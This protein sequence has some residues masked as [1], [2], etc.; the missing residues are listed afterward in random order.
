M[1]NLRADFVALSQTPSES[2]MFQYFDFLAWLDSK[3]SGKTFAEVM[4]EKY[5]RE[6]N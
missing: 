2:V 3:I 5:R 6:E 4:A 1:K